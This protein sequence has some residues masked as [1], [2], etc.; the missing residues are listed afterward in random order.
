MPERESR[1]D[2]CMCSTVT[3]PMMAAHWRSM[4]SPRTPDSQHAPGSHSTIFSVLIAGASCHLRLAHKASS[5]RC[6][7]KNIMCSAGGTRY[8]QLLV[9]SWTVQ[10]CD[11]L[12][13]STRTVTCA[14][15]LSV[16]HNYLRCK[17]LHSLVS[18][19]RVP[20][21]RCALSWAPRLM[22]NYT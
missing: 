19:L 2:A 8:T 20:T 15:S 13:P 17:V 12:V 5:L 1:V 18:S 4:R 22:D 14:G 9:V 3:L 21:D 11:L 16:T 6:L 7:N 10:G